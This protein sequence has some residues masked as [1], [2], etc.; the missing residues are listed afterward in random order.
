MHE[1]SDEDSNDDEDDDDD[2]DDD[3]DELRYAVARSVPF[4]TIHR[5][6]DAVSTSEPE[7]PKLFHHRADSA[8]SESISLIQ[9]LQNDP[10]Y[11]VDN[12]NHSDVENVYRKVANWV[13]SQ[14][15]YLQ[16]ADQFDDDEMEVID[17]IDLFHDSL[18]DDFL[19]LTR[20]SSEKRILLR[21][22]SSY[23]YN[24]LTVKEATRTYECYFLKK[25]I[26]EALVEMTEIA[27]DGKEVEED[28]EKSFVAV[29]T[30][31]QEY[32]IYDRE[33]VEIVIDED[34]LDFDNS[35]HSSDEE[36]SIVGDSCMEDKEQRSN[37]L[38]I[39]SYHCSDVI[40]RNHNSDDCT[41]LT[42]PTD[43]F[44]IT[45][46]FVA[47]MNS[48]N[49]ENESDIWEDAKAIP[50]WLDFENEDHL[51]NQPHRPFYYYRDRIKGCYRIIGVEDETVVLFS[52]NDDDSIFY[53][54]ENEE[55]NMTDI[56]ALRRSHSLGLLNPSCNK[57]R[58]S[59]MSKTVTINL[60]HVTHSEKRND[61][62]I[63]DAED[64]IL[65]ETVVESTL[66]AK[67]CN[68]L[69]RVTKFIRGKEQKTVKFKLENA[70]SSFVD[71]LFLVLAIIVLILSIILY[72][73]T[74][75]ST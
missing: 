55:R 49:D 74:N 72:F 69:G 31:L 16:K 18:L 51:F 48:E 53:G 14:Q 9:Q 35:A 13:F 5:T 58:E 61:S 2:N 63:E 45:T 67:E 38:E 25:P 11:A 40:Q 62:G 33:S 17:P 68:D 47:E 23:S 59:F 10:L 7:F 57:S 26:K 39:V 60:N 22:F 41:S 32:A 20:S 64:L 6:I 42:Y 44:E 3:D 56:S 54:C 27:Y 24:M 37:E 71:Y 12:I 73:M 21:E 70:S 43:V 28:V 75:P 29:E 52:G 65:D 34:Y 8:T 50:H 30:I 66:S 36:K 1:S 4:P 46:A 15:R 19:L